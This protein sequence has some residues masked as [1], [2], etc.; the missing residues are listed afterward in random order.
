[1]R[2]LMSTRQNKAGRMAGDCLD[3]RAGCD[4]LVDFRPSYLNAEVY[5][6]PNSR[7]H[8]GGLA[9]TRVWP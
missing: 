9:G 6:A 7:S 3:Q 4:F 5:M 2:L 8:G 1:M